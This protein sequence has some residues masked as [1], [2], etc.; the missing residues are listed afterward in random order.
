MMRNLRKNIWGGSLVQEPVPSDNG[1]NSKTNS[2]T[3][4]K[5]SKKQRRKSKKGGTHT[6]GKQQ[7]YKKDTEKG[8]NPSMN[9]KKQPT[10]K[11]VTFADEYKEPQNS[12]GKMGAGE[13]A[14]G[15][16]GP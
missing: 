3:N 8:T 16:G 6:K 13:A 12:D 4:S 9:V 11:K 1:E 10:T 14:G 5:K 15:R 7:N 2:K